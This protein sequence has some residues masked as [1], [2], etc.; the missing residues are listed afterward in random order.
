MYTLV[1]SSGHVNRFAI[2]SQYVRFESEQS[3]G[4]EAFWRR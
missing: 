1:L 4:W 2:A 3:T